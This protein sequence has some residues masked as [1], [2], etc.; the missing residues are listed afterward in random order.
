MK[1]FER[2][3][4]TTLYISGLKYSLKEGHIREL[5]T[6][7]GKIGEIDLIKDKKTGL[8]KGVAFIAMPE[9]EDAEKSSQRFDGTQYAGR[10]LKV[11]IANQRFEK[12]TAYY[13]AQ[14][15][16]AAKMAKTKEAKEEDEMPKKSLRRRDKKGLNV[17]F[18]HL[19][20]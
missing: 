13:A 16:K 5:L 12:D 3:N 4:E 6:P 11:S 8:K 9:K 17:L 15:S 14:R 7:Y 10:T 18:N 2:T 1:K 19:G 20:K